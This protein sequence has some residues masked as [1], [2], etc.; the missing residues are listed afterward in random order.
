[1]TLVTISELQKMKIGCRSKIYSLIKTHNFPKPL[2]IGQR[3]LWQLEDVQQWLN[4]Q[5]PNK[6]SI[7]Q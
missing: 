5:N 3:S 6:G 2:K 4:Q 7:P 1:M